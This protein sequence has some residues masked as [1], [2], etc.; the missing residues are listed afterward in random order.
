MGLDWR[1]ERGW[2]EEMF[3]VIDCYASVLVEIKSCIHAGAS[4]IL[5]FQQLIV[6]H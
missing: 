4:V 6:V 5:K 2:L 3:P 1:G